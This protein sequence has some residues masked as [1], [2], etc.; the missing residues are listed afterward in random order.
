MLT[1]LAVLVAFVLLPCSKSIGI[2]CT[3]PVAANSNRRARPREPWVGH[4]SVRSGAKAICRCNSGGD[5]VQT[6]RMVG[7]A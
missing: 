5:N 3:Q 1:R 6:G 4:H 2:R 7:R